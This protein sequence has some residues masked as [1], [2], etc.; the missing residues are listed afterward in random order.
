MSE[1]PTIC[2]FFGGA[3]M[4]KYVCTLNTNTAH[5][6]VLITQNTIL[7]ATSSHC[8]EDNQQIIEVM[9]EQWAPGRFPKQETSC[10]LMYL[11]DAL[12]I[13]SALG[14]FKWAKE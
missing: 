9:K 13:G 5:W 12:V 10:L 2:T 6:I 3:A 14:I 4:K 1:S 7:S 11:V 8:G